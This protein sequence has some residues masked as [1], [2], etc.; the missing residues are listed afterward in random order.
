L[1][2]Q[3]RE[4]DRT[5]RLSLL[6][7]AIKTHIA[8]IYLYLKVNVLGRAYGESFNNGVGDSTRFQRSCERLFGLAALIDNQPCDYK[9]AVLAP[10][11]GRFLPRP[12]PQDK[13]KGLVDVIKTAIGLGSEEKP[14][15]KPIQGTHIWL[16][17][18]L[19]VF[20]QFML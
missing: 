7:H 8:H 13:P 5:F 16:F 11:E 19:L 9:Y 3:Q 10:A 4:G 14:E 20:I 12:K 2:L 6:V 15:P 17:L 18:F 1:K